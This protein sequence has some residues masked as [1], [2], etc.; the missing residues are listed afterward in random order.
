MVS[1]CEQF[2]WSSSFGAAQKG[3]GHISTDSE[4]KEARQVEVEVK[5]RLEF[6]P[7][8][9]RILNVFHH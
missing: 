1:D 9:S 2:I 7:G 3:P 4:N 6:K 5:G 8:H